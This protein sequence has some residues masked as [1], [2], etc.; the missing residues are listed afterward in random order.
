MQIIRLCQGLGTEGTSHC[1]MAATSIVAGEAF[2]DLPVCV[3]PTI[4]RALI[5]INDACPSNK[6]RERLL[7]HLPWLIIGTRSDN[8]G[9]QVVRAKKFDAY[10]ADADAADAADADAAAYA[11]KRKQRKRQADKLVEL[12]EQA[13]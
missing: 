1:V 8:I 11:A 13:A 6:I 4:T 9:I 2:T 5:A 3:C 12:L 10:A 7:G